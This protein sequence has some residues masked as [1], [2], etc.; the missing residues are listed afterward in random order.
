MHFFPFAIR[1]SVILHLDSCRCYYR[2]YFR[3][4]FFFPREL[5]FFENANIEGVSSMLV[6]QCWFATRVRSAV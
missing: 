5:A 1:R 6:I 4:F 3:C 2:S